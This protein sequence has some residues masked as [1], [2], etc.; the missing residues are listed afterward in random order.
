MNSRIKNVLILGAGSAGLL[1]S[2]SLKRKIPE[3]TVRIVRSP[4]IGTIGVGEGTTVAFPE[5]LFGY[6][7]LGRKR[8]HAVAEPTWKLGLRF[9]WGP[10]DFFDYTFAKQMDQQWNDLPMPHGFYCKEEFVNN[11][12][13]SAL[14]AQGKAF[15]RQPNGAGPD[16]Q[17]HFGY[18]IENAKLIEAL[19]GTALEWGVEFIDGKV[20][21]AERGPDGISA[22]HLDDGRKMEADF[23]IDSSGFRSELLGR[24]LEVP[25]IPY[26]KSLFCDRAVVGGWDRTVE[27]ILPYT[28]VETMDAGWAWQIEHEHHIN[29]GYVFSSAHISDDAAREEFLR[30]NPKAAKDG[31]IV[32]FN[33]GRR[34]RLWVDNVVGVG[35][36]AGFVEPLEATAL[37][38]VCNQT[39]AIVDMLIHNN[40]QP[41]KTMREVY[42]QVLGG[43]WDEI[44]DFLAIHYYCN[45][46]INNEFWHRCRTETDISRTEPLL[47]FYK[48]NGPSGLGRYNMREDLSSFGIE[49]Y[50][51]QFVGNKVPYH[52]N[53]KPSDADLRTWNRHRQHHAAQACAGMDVA[54]TLAILRHPQWTWHEE[55]A[56]R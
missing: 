7:G 22:V 13:I 34:E 40:L 35:N 51:V 14:M 47:Q 27:P 33:T 20:S 29:R 36:A 46:R 16:I 25:F 1:A 45:T 17:P 21:G 24:V 38:M 44:R 41:T 3:L 5:H 32:K 19:E 39:R 48:E 50:L 53:Y 15:L 54:E 37:M 6:L 4:E 55:L 2:L 8:F 28:G 18:H 30:K 52:T 56:K 11:D 12:P 31:R 26:T 42:N 43:Q 23:F 49:G 10:R 9:F